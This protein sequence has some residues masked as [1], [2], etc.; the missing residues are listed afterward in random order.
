MGLGRFFLIGSMAAVLA[1]CNGADV[2]ASPTTVATPTAI[3]SS[4]TVTASSTATPSPTKSTPM[5]S[6]A[7]PISAREH[8]FDGATSF[9]RFYF[10]EVNAAWMKPDMSRISN[11]A[12]AD[13]KSCANYE[14]SA[15]ELALKGHRY[16]T[17][18]SRNFDGTYLPEST[19]NLVV[20]HLPSRQ[21]KANIVN[22]KGEIV[23][24]TST[25]GFL[26]EFKVGWTTGGWMIR[27][28]EPVELTDNAE[29]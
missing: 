3:T 15:K 20:V 2:G 26:S 8:S 21:L 5:E 25:G 7:I 10:E 22:A 1:A 17:V 12:D 18:P 13:C 6:S 27:S 16:E 19:K 23:R 9:A 24:T 28:I 11:L 4:P 14:N 29:S